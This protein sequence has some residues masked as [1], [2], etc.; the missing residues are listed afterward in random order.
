MI[1][2]LDDLLTIELNEYGFQIETSWLYF[3]IDW[4]FISTAA[5]VFIG[6]KAYKIW[7]DKW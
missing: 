3:A 6:Y 5:L 4:R 2:G 7:R 1:N